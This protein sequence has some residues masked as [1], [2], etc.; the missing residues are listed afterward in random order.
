VDVEIKVGKYDFT[1]KQGELLL[2]WKV[3]QIL[4]SILLAAQHA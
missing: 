3:D 4:L 2:I 1:I